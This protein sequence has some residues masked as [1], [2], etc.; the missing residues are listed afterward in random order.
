M[1]GAPDELANCNLLEADGSLVGQLTVAWPRERRA[2]RRREDRG[3]WLG[4]RSKSGEQG[5]RRRCKTCAL[6]RSGYATGTT[7]ATASRMTAATAAGC[8]RKTACEAPSTSVTVI[9]ARW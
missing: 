4:H 2:R 8:D 1:G 7:A 5:A 6:L 3:T 9:P